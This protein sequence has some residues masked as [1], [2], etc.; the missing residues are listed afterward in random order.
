MKKSY[1]AIIIS[2]LTLALCACG[3][4]PANIPSDAGQNRETVEDARLSPAQET[5][6]ARQERGVIRPLK[7][8]VCSAVDEND[9]T[10]LA[11]DFIRDLYET[12][13]FHDE[14]AL[15]LDKYFDEGELREQM[16]DCRKALSESDAPLEKEYFDFDYVTAVS[17]KVT[18]N[19]VHLITVDY[20][21]SFRYPNYPYDPENPDEGWSGSGFRAPFAVRDGKILNLAVDNIFEALPSDESTPEVQIVLSHIS[22]VRDGQFELDGVTYR[23]ED[24]ELELVIDDAAFIKLITPD[25]PINVFDYDGGADELTDAVRNIGALICLGNT[26]RFETDGVPF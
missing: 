16:S 8:T 14:T 5:G 18:D 10:R 6:A 23:R 20:S 24:G 1:K 22:A 13:I 19:G 2:V 7:E 21:Y 12:R 9:E 17:D 15:D 4:Q 11:V 25:G 3:V 26:G